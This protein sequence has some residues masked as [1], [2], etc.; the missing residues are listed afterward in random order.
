MEP[1]NEPG[2]TQGDAKI[3]NNVKND[4]DRAYDELLKKEQEALETRMRNESTQNYEK[5]RALGF[6]TKKDIEEQVRGMFGKFVEETEKIREE[7][8][9]LREWVMRAKAQGL[10]SGVTEDK[11]KDENLLKAHERFKF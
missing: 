2:P 8:R 6:A 7:N 1:T 9:Q 5:V 10:N 4:F 11:P 3:E